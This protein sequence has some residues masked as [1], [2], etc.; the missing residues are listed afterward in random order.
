MAPR[1]GPVGLLR[2]QQRTFERQELLVDAL[3]V[4]CVLEQRRALRLLLAG[5]L[6]LA[7][8]GTLGH[9][10]R[11]SGPHLRFSTDI[12]CPGR[13]LSEAR[14]RARR[15]RGGWSARRPASAH[16]PGR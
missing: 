15:R 5:Q 8:R 2:P 10:D 1:P 11:V 9:L 14:T 3:P 7:V 4:E 13:W 12:L 6:L 16:P